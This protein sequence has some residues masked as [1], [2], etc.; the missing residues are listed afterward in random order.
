VFDTAYNLIRTI[1]SAGEGD[2]ELNF[3]MDTEIIS[4]NDGGTMVQ[5]VVVAD[6]GNKRIQFFDT[7]GNHLQTIAEMEP[8]P[9]PPG[10]QCGWFNP[11]PECL[12]PE[13]GQL[14]ALSVDSQGRLHALDLLQ[15]TIL[16]LDPVSGE[17]I[18]AYGEYGNGPGFLKLPMDAFVSSTGET[19]V[20][21]GDGSR[22]E[23][24]TT[25]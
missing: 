13:F 7:L 19:I 16:M 20:T 15:G 21:S 25:P 23:V 12:S 9:P 24:L 10:V 8:P 3:P 6:Q 2:G 4:W 5:E 11:D 22:I 14:Q 17:F 18:S 1:G